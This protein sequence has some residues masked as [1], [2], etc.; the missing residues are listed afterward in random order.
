MRRI[1]WPCLGALAT[2][3]SL[4]GCDAQDTGYVQVQLAQPAR[5]GGIGAAP[6]FLH[7][8]KLD[9]SRGQAVVMQFRTGRVAL[10]TSDSTWSPAICRIVVRKNRISVL[11]VAATENPPRCICQIRAPDS[12]PSESVCT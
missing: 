6:L 12:T 3:L 1:G 4:A 9:F 7:G 11:S 2:A 10:K 5:P 8:A